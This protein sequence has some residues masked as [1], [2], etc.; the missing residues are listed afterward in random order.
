MFT[1]SVTVRHAVGF[2]VDR[3]TGI[4]ANSHQFSVCEATIDGADGFIFFIHY[5]LFLK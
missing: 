5:N 2:T 1:F 4:A 3:D